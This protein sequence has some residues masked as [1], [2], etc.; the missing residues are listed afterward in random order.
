[1]FVATESLPSI[2]VSLRRPEVPGAA[3][4]ER[5]D[6]D[7]LMLLA[8]SDRRDAFRVLANVMR[9]VWSASACA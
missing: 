1:L 9:C 7:D 4:A 6:D 5:D 3:L 2:V 8:S